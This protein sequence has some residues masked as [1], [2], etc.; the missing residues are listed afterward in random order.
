MLGKASL[1]VFCA[2]LAFVFVGLA[3][4][5]GT[6]TQLHGLYAVGLVALTFVGLIFVALR[7]TRRERQ[8][9]TTNHPELKIIPPLT[10]VLGLTG[11]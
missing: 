10:Y 4:L 5:Y 7:K 6:V 2:H 1:Q 9:Q 8:E 11:D 3:L